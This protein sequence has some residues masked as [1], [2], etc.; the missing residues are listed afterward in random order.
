MPSLSLSFSSQVVFARRY[1]LDVI[2][3]GPVAF[4]GCTLVSDN[5]TS[6]QVI[7]LR[8]SNASN[9]SAAQERET[10]IASE[11][12]QSFAC[13]IKWCIIINVLQYISNNTLQKWALILFLSQLNSTIGASNPHLLSVSVTKY[14]TVSSFVIVVAEANYDTSNM[15]TFNIAPVSCCEGEE[16]E[17]EKKDCVCVW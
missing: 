5:T 10:Q 15:T 13:C 17:E 9:V 7:T 2:G 16:S 3:W 11:V 6:F 14:Y 8:L 1:C 4:S 12:S